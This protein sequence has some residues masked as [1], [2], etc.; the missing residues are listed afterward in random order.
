MQISHTTYE[1]SD[2]KSQLTFLVSLTDAASDGISCTSYRNSI[3]LDPLPYFCTRINLQNA[4][5]CLSQE[6][7]GMGLN[8][9]FIDL[10]SQKLNLISLVN[11]C[12]EMTQL[13]RSAV[14]DSN[15]LLDQ[16]RRDASDISHFQN[17]VK[18]LRTS[19]EEKERLVCDAQER[20]RQALSVNKTLSSKFK[21]EKDEVRR[22]NSVLQQREAHHQH[23]L[24]KKETENNRLRERLHR[25]VSGERLSETRPIAIT[26]SNTLTRSNRSRATWKTEAS[27]A[28]HE[29]EMHRKVLGQYETWVG[30]LSDENEQLKGCLSAVTSHISKIVNRFANNE[31]YLNID[32]EFNS[33]MYSSDSLENPVFML[34]FPAVREQ[35]QQTLEEYL[36]V[37]TQLIEGKGGDDSLE[38]S[39][40]TLKKECEDLQ[41]ELARTKDQFMALKLQQEMGGCLAKEA[42]IPD[43]L[44]VE[45]L[46]MLE[47][48]KREIEE[49]RKALQKERGI[50]TDAAIRL[51]RE[52]AAFEAEKVELLKRQFLQE[53][54]PALSTSVDM[55]TSGHESACSVSSG[56]F[57]ELFTDSPHRKIGI[58]AI[59]P[60]RVSMNLTRVATPIVLGPTRLPKQQRDSQA[61]Y[62]MKKPAHRLKSAP[63]SR[64]P[65]VPRQDDE[66]SVFLERENNIRPSSSRPS[67]LERR[68][69]T[70]S[71]PYRFRSQ[72]QSRLDAAKQDLMHSREE[73][74]SFPTHFEGDLLHSKGVKNQDV[75]YSSLPYNNLDHF[76]RVCRDNVAETKIPTP[77]KR[78][79]VPQ[80]A[81]EGR[82]YQKYLCGHNCDYK[83]DDQTNLKIL[84]RDLLN[85][86]VKIGQRHGEAATVSSEEPPPY[87]AVIPKLYRSSTPRVSAPGSLASS[88]RSSRDLTNVD[89]NHTRV[90]KPLVRQ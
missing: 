36:K 73:F 22:L 45:E 30:Q 18:D 56:S 85:L 27:G 83:D 2:K 58:P 79:S 53:L 25:L 49:E 71:T 15:S 29:E 6:L 52:R 33:S 74:S 24:R 59:T 47:K 38:K 35:V 82:C 20:E 37:I 10:P 26:V 61:E 76:S 8:C 5:V 17:N 67:T 48:R 4:I 55:T 44:F 39:H 77:S 62:S 88:R 31:N 40:L 64:A 81:C 34:E 23:E 72:S 80:S 12:W 54:P 7:Q 1:M 3:G 89:E 43:D 86:I 69:K 66:C 21:S 63:V 9:N 51:N 11:A 28:R 16:R 57:G 19:V 75:K 68:R 90:H 14:R 65:S 42:I 41:I 78:L 60:P 50:F 84:E 32:G 13:Y 70:S 87:E 46:S